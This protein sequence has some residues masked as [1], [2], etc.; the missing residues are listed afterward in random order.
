[1]SV[2]AFFS[3]L[4]HGS[5]SLTFADMLNGNPS[6]ATA[7]DANGDTALHVAARSGNLS[8]LIALAPLKPSLDAVDKSGLTPINVA[9]S[10]QQAGAIIKLVEMGATPDAD[11][12]GVAPIH[13][14]AKAGDVDSLRAL[15]MLGAKA[16]NGPSVLHWAVEG[17]SVFAIGTILYEMEVP[18]DTLD[19]AS[20]TALM[21]ALR[22]GKSNVALFLLEHGANVSITSATQDS[23]LHVAAE[24]AT[25]DD[26]R[27]LVGYGASK[28]AKNKAGSTP[29]EVATSKNVAANIKELSR[30]KAPEGKEAAMRFKDHGNKVFG[31]GEN[32]KAA[33]FYT[34]AIQLDPSNH[35]FYS[36]RSACFFNQGQYKTAYFDACRCIALAPQ[37]PKGYF[38]KAATEQALKDIPAAKETVS[39]GLHAVPGNADLVKLQNELSKSK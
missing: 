13:Y 5:E 36:N 31:N 16:L 34:Q 3:A 12:N 20:E 11:K 23:A 18:V 35:V 8:A 39:N 25:A 22:M 38:R 29:L 1:M 9:A 15:K 28:A 4:Q 10:S 24:F 2:E 32:M 7:V 19:A 37:W 21:K 17:G 27:T 26:I 14:A 30:T 6:F 33:R